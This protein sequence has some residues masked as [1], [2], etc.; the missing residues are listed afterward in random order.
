MSDVHDRFFENLDA[1]NSALVH[2]FLVTKDPVTQKLHNKRAQILRNGLAVTGFVIL[3][4]FV[5]SRTSEIIQRIGTGLTSFNKLPEGIKA[6]ATEG[7]VKALLVQIKRGVTDSKSKSE[8]I[9]DHAKKIGNTNGSSYTVSHLSFFHDKSNVDKSDIENILTA[10]KV[11]NPWGSISGIAKNCGLGGASDY[12]AMFEAAS[13]RRHNA[14]HSIF[15]ETEISDLI[16]FSEQILGFA[17]GFEFLL[18]TALNLIICLDSDYTIKKSINHKAV[19]LKTL[20]LKGKVWRE[21]TFGRSRA[22]KTDAS[23]DVLIESC[24]KKSQ[25]DG[26]CVVIKNSKGFPEAW[27]TPFI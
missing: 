15:A 7:V 1:F 18:S 17:I 12:K 11:D 26:S 16:S 23:K 22:T 5:K 9:Q 14:A 24:L 25:K 2:E 6:A 3:E 21:I 20:E 19:R 8:F 10:F 13:A 4:D 27:H